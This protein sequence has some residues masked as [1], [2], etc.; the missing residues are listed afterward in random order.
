MSE[1]SFDEIN[2]KYRKT[3]GK[4]VF[5]SSITN[6]ST[7]FINALIYASV[8][9]IGSFLVIAASLTVGELTSLLMCRMHN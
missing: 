5:Y 6:P 1:M 2:E 4:A 8:A 7:R 3:S 9:L